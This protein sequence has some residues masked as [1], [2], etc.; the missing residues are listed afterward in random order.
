[1]KKILSIIL[2]LTFAMQPAYSVDQQ[3]QPAKKGMITRVKEK[4]SAMKE[5]IKR[6]Q[7]ALK[8]NWQCI[9]T[10]KG[11]KCSPDRYLALQII[12]NFIKG[13][14]KAAKESLQKLIQAH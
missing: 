6:G 7:A 3:A 9:T 8:A 13:N 10:G 2:T 11:E 4:F 12:R 1:M 14:M 5:V